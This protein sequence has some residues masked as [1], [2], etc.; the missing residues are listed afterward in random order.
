MNYNLVDLKSES[1]TNEIFHL[2]GQ[3]LVFKIKKKNKKQ[4]DYF[5]IRNSTELLLQVTDDIILRKR[6]HLLSLV[7]DRDSVQI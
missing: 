2:R 7:D 3:D 4:Q 5:E 6:L 1:Q